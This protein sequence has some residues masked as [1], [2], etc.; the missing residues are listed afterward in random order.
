MRVPVEELRT[1]FAASGLTPVELAQR[2]G[3]RERRNAP[4]RTDFWDGRR[5][6]RTLGLRASDKGHGYGFSERKAVNPTTAQEIRAAL[7]NGSNAA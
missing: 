7:R 4:G 5:V 2:L 1:E 3:W 6:M